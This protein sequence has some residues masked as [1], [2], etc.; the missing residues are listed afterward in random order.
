MHCVFKYF[1]NVF[2][3]IVDCF[4]YLLFIF[5]L[6]EF[7]LRVLPLNRPSTHCPVTL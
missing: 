1:Q 4:M 6:D 2:M 5:C 3:F 7:F